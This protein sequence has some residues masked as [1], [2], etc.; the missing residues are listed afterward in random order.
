MQNEVSDYDD[1]HINFLETLWGE[2][3][4]SPGGS[5][6]VELIIGEVDLNHKKILDFG[7]G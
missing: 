6:E 5:N 3:F 4:L 7:C 2:G 1:S